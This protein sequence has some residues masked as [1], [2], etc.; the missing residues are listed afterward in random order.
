MQ[1]SDA[2]FYEPDLERSCAVDHPRAGRGNRGRRVRRP[3]PVT[4]RMTRRPVRSGRVTDWRA[5]L[6]DDLRLPDGLSPADAVAELTEAARSPD[7]VLRDEL[8]LTVLLDLVP[9]LDPG[10][11]RT[12]GASMAARFLDPEIQ[13]RT[14]AALILA[15]LVSQGEFEPS[16][17]AAFAGLVPGRDRPARLRPGTRLA[18]RGRAR[19]RPARRLRPLPAGRPGLDAAA[20]RARLL[21]PTDYVL[22]DQEDDRLGYAMA[23]TC[24]RAELTE[25]E[26][27]GWLDPVAADFEAGG[28]GPVPPY[29]SNTMR[30]LR[31]LYLLADRGVLPPGGGD[32]MPLAHPTGEAATGRGP[33]AGRAVRGLSFSNSEPP[34]T[35]ATGRSAAGHQGGR[36]ASPPVTTFSLMTV[37]S[38]LFR[39][40]VLVLLGGLLAVGPAVAAGSWREGSRRPAQYRGCVQRP[41]VDLPTNVL[42][43]QPGGSRS[44]GFA[45]QRGNAI[46]AGRGG[47]SARRPSTSADQHN[48]T[49]PEREFV[50]LRIAV[51]GLQRPSSS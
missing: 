33:V 19:G 16:W 27:V 50:T 13:A 41:G 9:R 5:V 21:A 10:L 49:D 34:A 26:S 22:R 40:T 43:Q 29:A 51:A 2:I 12:L 7:P 39:L 37:L 1:W 38:R 4:S 25:E 32:P 48:S 15:E 46:P 18:A 35:L 23:L 28:P 36:S 47:P 24:T 14:F 20:G 8:G 30:T 3:G 44:P 31:M 11:R 45:R 17:L 6:E 42:G